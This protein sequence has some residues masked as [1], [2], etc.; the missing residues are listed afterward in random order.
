M[1]YADCIVCW[2]D[3]DDRHPHTREN[4][5][6]AGLVGG[7][8][9]VLRRGDRRV[10]RFHNTA[11]GAFLAVRDLDPAHR[12]L[13]CLNTALLLL[14]DCRLDPAK[15]HAAFNEIDEYR[16][17]GFV[18]SAIGG[19]EGYRAALQAACRGQD[20]GELWRF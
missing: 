7:E 16:H 20:P 17:T 4:N 3:P 1:R 11:G 2:N 14:I 19:Q 8:I 13:H 5:K 10:D 6:K 15:V 12:A 18:L 9:A